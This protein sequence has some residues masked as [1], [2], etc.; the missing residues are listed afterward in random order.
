M[1]NFSFWTE[2]D[3]ESFTVTTLEKGIEIKHT[4]YFAICACLNRA[5]KNG[6]PLVDAHYMAAITE[7]QLAEIFKSDSGKI[8]LKYF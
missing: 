8:F 3:E 4:G 6:I 1:I 5:L 7:T 2:N